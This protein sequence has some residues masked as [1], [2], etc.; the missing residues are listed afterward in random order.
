[1]V[2][3]I[4]WSIP[5]VRVDVLNIDSKNAQTLHISPSDMDRGYSKWQDNA[6]SATM[7]S[8]AQRDVRLLIPVLSNAIRNP[9]Q[10]SIKVRVN[11]LLPPPVHRKN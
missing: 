2:S 5:L 4:T 3:I 1:M 8:N 6:H 11:I 9:S 7:G 10:V